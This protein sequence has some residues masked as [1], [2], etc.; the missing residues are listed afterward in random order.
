M[1][2]RYEWRD[3][4]LTYEELQWRQK[5]LLTL[6]LLEAEDWGQK[7]I[8]VPTIYVVN[9]K[10]STKAKMPRE[11]VYISITPAGDVVFVYR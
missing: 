2:V 10:R 8:W 5:Q 6:P 4:R 7:L 9:D 11:N 1:M 3:P